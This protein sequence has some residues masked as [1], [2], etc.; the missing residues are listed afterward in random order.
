M[1]RII[2]SIA[3]LFY[4]ATSVAA[5][6]IVLASPIDCSLGKDCY[7]Q[8]YV[9]HKEGKGAS[10]F[11]CGHLSYERHKGTDFALRTLKQMRAGVNVL[12]SAPG[13]VKAARNGI[14]DVIYSANNA[15]KVN[16]RE[17]GNGVVIQ[18]KNGWETQYCHMKKSSVEVRKGQTV[19]AGTILGKVGLSGR[20][21]FP[22]VHL[23]VR[24]N[25]KVVDPFD[26]DGQITCGSPDTN[27][28]WESPLPYSEGGVLYAAF[29][30]G[31]PKFYDVKSGRAA[32]NTLPENA[33]AIVVFGFGFGAKKGDQMRLILSGPK[34]VMLNELVSITKNQAQLF[35]AE[36]KRL[37][38]E[39]WQSGTYTGSVSLIRDGRV[40]NTE[41]AKTIVR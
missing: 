8:Q 28:L 3:A 40:I 11:R 17:C 9:D 20:T 33:P 37:T 10:D 19:K 32:K 14:D 30:D 12:S 36:G 39:K 24:N 2:L 38:A 31:V 1:I 15:D 22:H 26:P 13:I 7:I 35:R 6:D 16:G 4:A 18:H 41:K 25:G 23:T 27:T 5:Q 29:S 34:G 21:Q